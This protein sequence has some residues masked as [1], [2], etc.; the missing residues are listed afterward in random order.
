MCVR[1]AVAPWL[2]RDSVWHVNSRG[3]KALCFRW[4]PGS[5]HGKMQFW[6]DFLLIEKHCEQLLR[7]VVCCM[8]ATWSCGAVA[9][10]SIH[11][12]MGPWWKLLPIWLFSDDVAFCQITLTFCYMLQHYSAK[13][14]VFC[15][16]QSC[17]F[18]LS[19]LSAM[20]NW[21]A[22]PRKFLLSP[23]YTVIFW[24]DMCYS[25]KIVIL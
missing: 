2:D 15:G 10:I 12:A 14:T 17:H 6:G 5:P 4:G 21:L 22:V 19:L 8:F 3:P 13:C 18:C 11:K 7:N 25:T 23:I 16:I 24:L 9:S 1:H 20:W